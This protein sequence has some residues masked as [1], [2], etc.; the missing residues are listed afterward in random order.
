MVE[1][2]VARR[3]TKRVV[4]TLCMIRRSRNSSPYHLREKPFHTT[5]LSPALKEKTMS[6]KMGA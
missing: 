2:M 1:M 3:D 6:R 4:Y 5:L